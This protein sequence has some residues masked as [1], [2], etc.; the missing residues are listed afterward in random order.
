ML[1]GWRGMAYRLPIHTF[2]EEKNSSQTIQES[3]FMHL[4][5]LDRASPGFSFENPLWHIGS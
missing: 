4:V 1:R 5:Y 3:I 2:R